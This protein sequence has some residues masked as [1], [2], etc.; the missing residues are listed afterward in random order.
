MKQN[1]RLIFL[2]ALFL[3]SSEGYSQRDLNSGVTDTLLHQEWS[4][5]EREFELRLEVLSELQEF[6]SKKKSYKKLSD[7]IHGK[8]IQVKNEFRNLDGASLEERKAIAAVQHSLTP[9]VEK[10][11]TVDLANDK[12]L[13][14]DEDYK[15]IKIVF[16]G[17]QNRMAI[18]LHLYNKKALN[19]KRPDLVLPGGKNI[20]IPQVEF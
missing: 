15:R 18:A 9:Q 10:W 19:I 7:E 2:F 16:A 1:L 8:L 6:L 11:L 17:I 3:L 14:R 20:A 4:Q 5:V 12:V 13:E